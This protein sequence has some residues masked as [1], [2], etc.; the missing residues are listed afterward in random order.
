MPQ[1]GNFPHQCF[2]FVVNFC[3]YG[4]NVV[5][6]LVSSS[7]AFAELVGSLFSMLL[8]DLLFPAAVLSTLFLLTVCCFVHLPI[9]VHTHV[10]TVSHNAA[11]VP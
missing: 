6:M 10:G 7:A 2:A 8:G 5:S 4:L 9:L 3:V 11:H 1:A